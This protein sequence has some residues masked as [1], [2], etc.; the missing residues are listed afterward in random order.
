MMSHLKRSTARNFFIK[1]LGSTSAALDV[2]QTGTVKRTDALYKW[3]LL[4][5]LV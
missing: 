4:G 5:S 3:E 1:P 2:P